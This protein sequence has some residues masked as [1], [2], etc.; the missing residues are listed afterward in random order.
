MA[1]G[2]D[3]VWVSFSDGELERVDPATAKVDLHVHL[4]GGI[5]AVA[6]DA[7]GV[8]TLNALAG[9][10]SGIDPQT[11]DVLATAPVSSN[12][13]YLAAGEGAS[14]SSKRSPRR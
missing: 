7:D 12:A 1:F 3:V 11:G 5:D 6:A 8:W 14:G 9:T 2:A 4:E 13:R 10:V